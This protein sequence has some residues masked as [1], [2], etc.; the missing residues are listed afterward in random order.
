MQ[1]MGCWLRNQGLNPCPL[2]CKAILNHWT[3]R[4][5]L[6]LPFPEIPGNPS[7]LAALFAWSL[8]C[9]RQTH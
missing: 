5:A 1:H 9:S 7:I 6:E 8:P 4:E 3:T 2:H